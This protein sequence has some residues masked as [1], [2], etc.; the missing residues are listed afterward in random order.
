MN[1]GLHR[2]HEITKPTTQYKP[3][4]AP[5]SLT[6][7]NQRPTS[8]AEGKWIKKPNILND[9]N[10]APPTNR[11]EQLL[12]FPVLDGQYTKPTL[13]NS[14]H[15]Q[16]VLPTPAPNGDRDDIQPPPPPVHARRVL[17]LGKDIATP[18]SQS[19]MTQSWME[20]DEYETVR[21]KPES[22]PQTDGLDMD[23]ENA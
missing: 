4:L 7:N 1:Y 9:S 19:A 14:Q 21:S 13:S 17:E 6:I 2:D 5:D 8:V 20:L 18:P 23:I 11:S 3:K 16:L 15:T 10:F 22:N 12:T